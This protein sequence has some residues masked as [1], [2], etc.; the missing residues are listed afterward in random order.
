MFGCPALYVGRKLA[1]CVYE[2]RIGMRVPKAVAARAKSTK[3]AGAFPF[4]SRFMAV[5]K[6]RLHYIREGCG[7]TLVFVHGNP[8]GASCIA[9]SFAHCARIMSALRRTSLVL[10]CHGPRLIMDSP[11]KSTSILSRNS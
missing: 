7:S 9:E 5:G 2:D 4:E 8:P 3:S 1:F 6:A 10:V 11:R